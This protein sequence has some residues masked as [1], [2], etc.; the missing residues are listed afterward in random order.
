[1]DVDGLAK[2]KGKEKTQ[3]ASQR[4]LMGKS[5]SDAQR[6]VFVELPAEACTDKSK[7]GRLLRSMYGCRDALVNREFAICQVL[8][9]TG[10][11]QG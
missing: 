1:M 10:F 9:A 11:E 8:V 3:G 2:T 6:K 4:S 5:Y 7:V